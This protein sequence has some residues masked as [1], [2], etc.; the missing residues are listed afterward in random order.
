[1]SVRD[2]LAR[3]VRSPRTRR[4][5]KA[6]VAAVAVLVLVPFVIYAFPTLAGAESSYIVLSGS[7]EP[8][9]EPGDVVVVYSTAPQNVEPGDVITY[10]RGGETPVTHRVTEVVTR[11]D[12][13]LAFRTKGDANEEVDAEA[14]PASALIGVV[15]TLQI[16]FVGPVLLHVP[17]VGVVIAGIN[18]SPVAFLMVLGAI[19]LLD[20]LRKAVGAG[21]R[22]GTQFGGAD[23]GGDASPDDDAGSGTV[24]GSG[25]APERSVAAAESADS[26]ATA[27]GERTLTVSGTDLRLTV[28]VLVAL[29]VYAGVAGL[30][31]QSPLALS[32]AAGALVGVVAVGSVVLGDEGGEATVDG[33]KG[34]EDDSS[35]LRATGGPTPVQPGRPVAGDVRVDAADM[36]V[37]AVD[38]AADL[39]DR[40][41]GFEGWVVRRDGEAA[42][43][44]GSVVYAYDGAD[45]DAELPVEG[46]QRVADTGL[47]DPRT[48][49][50]QSV[51]AVVQGDRGPFVEG[52]TATAP[53]D[54]APGE[55]G[56]DRDG[57]PRRPREGNAFDG[58]ET[59]EPA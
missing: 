47:T 52:K 25:D 33:S 12:G 14:V 4:G 9:L 39:V 20:E 43:T 37:V 27:A 46:D 22:P 49:D 42:V 11:D 35:G 2:R 44:D 6:L 58:G 41:E 54:L 55:G 56:D 17:L 31:G 15:P 21:W 16:P 8:A 1:M 32:V 18:R 59:D 40:A 57:G 48:G 3:A 23:D 29:A 36:P 26:S 7:M 30:L 45:V 53:P 38:S 10:R 24:P 13:S 51:A 28:A 19:I 34:D 50:A 5:A